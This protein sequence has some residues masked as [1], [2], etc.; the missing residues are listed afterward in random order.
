LN[1]QLE[2]I[3]N[4]VEAKRKVLD[5]KRLALDNLRNENQQIQR[6]QFDAEKKVAVADT[7]VQNLQRLIGQRR[8]CFC[9]GRKEIEIIYP[10]LSYAIANNTRA[11]NNWCKFCGCLG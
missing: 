11:G 7:S 2:Q 5:E 6:S 9:F 3:R 4:E 8:S 10:R 1:A